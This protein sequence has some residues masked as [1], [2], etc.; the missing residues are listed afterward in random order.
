MMDR[1]KDAFKEE[2]YELLNQLEQSLLELE[3]HPDRSDQVDA[4]FRVM[5]TVKGSASMFGF[6]G[7]SRFAHEME[8][9]LDHVR[10][11]RI[12]VGRQLI[13]HTLAARDHIRELLEEP[14]QPSDELAARSAELLRNFRSFAD[15]QLAAS[16]KQLREQERGADTSGKRESTT[17]G[18]E[19]LLEVPVTYRIHFKPA[20]ALFR[21]GTNPL[22]LIAEL[23]ELGDCTVIMHKDDIPPLDRLEP[24]ECY[25]FWD[26]LLTTR[27]PENAILD[28]FIFVQGS[29]DIT[30]E[31]VEDLDALADDPGYRKLGEILIARGIIPAS[32]VDR[33]IGR[34]RR[35]GQVLIEEEGVPASEVETALEEQ[36]H[37]RRM[38]E[39]AQRELSSSS[40]RVAS[41]KLDLL[42]D[43]V[44]ELVTVQA[45]LTRA[46]DQ[47][48]NGDLAVISEQIERLT[49]ELRDG[50]MSIRMVPIGTT[51][52]KFRRLVRDLAGELGKDADLVTVGG[53]TELDKT[54]IERLSDPLVHI[55][56]NSVDHGIEI[57]DT[58][59]QNGKPGRGT[60]RLSAYHSG[61][62]VLISIQDDGKGL[63]RD[64]ILQTARTRGIIAPEAELTEEE[65]FALIFAP[66]F[67][68]A[69]SVTQV[70]GRGVG[71]DVVRKEI[72]H[73]GGSVSVRSEPGRGT[74]ITLRIPLTLA[75]IEGLLVE[76]GGCSYVL[77]LSMVEE[78][79]E[80][81]AAD[82]ELH[83]GRRIVNNRG[84]ALP[85]TRL[86]ELLDIPGELPEI[87]QIVVVD[88]D[89]G[90][91]GFAVDRVVGD[92]Q[93]V[94]KNLGKMYR[95]VEGVSGATILGDGSIALIIDVQRLAE[96]AIRIETAAAS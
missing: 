41:E 94:I 74:E 30:V 42:V 85:F 52:S 36:A 53:E 13:D 23:E 55:I 16:E 92:H 18:A 38:R 63:D 56:R 89:H 6:D 62:S 70:S 83:I 27:H 86:R 68:T 21:N 90:R 81:T 40:I 49:A 78:C 58:R 25:A 77:P 24:E 3:E 11:G 19:D 96:M 72:E 67:S 46:A 48:G 93:T 8:T 82:R 76:S 71:M 5:H 51:F 80:L 9:I 12:P 87:E 1:F 26:I 37:L 20:R 39:K 43:L 61:A 88:G 15:A 17:A 79:L 4:V 34:Q 2:A 28:V 32:T 75:I 50:T 7:I 95:N 22:L 14:E 65:I 60:I 91:I 69:A 66:G 10:E 35:I 31:V 84:E 57:P 59:T 33:A 47:I 44:G 64:R 54:V 29:A 45:S 73:L